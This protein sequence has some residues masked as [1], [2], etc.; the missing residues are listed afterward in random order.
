MHFE[1][2]WLDLALYKI[3]LFI[4]LNVH[5]WYC[6]VRARLRVSSSVFSWVKYLYLGYNYT[7]GSV[8]L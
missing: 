4:A 6:V 3:T 8:T 7:E 1:Q 5:V 2:F